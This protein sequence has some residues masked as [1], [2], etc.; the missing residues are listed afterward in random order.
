MPLSPLPKHVF[1]DKLTGFIGRPSFRSSKSDS[2]EKRKSMSE[3]RKSV[4]KKE[5]E[6][7][8]E[9]AKDA[10]AAARFPRSK[11]DGAEDIFVDAAIIR[12]N[13]ARKTKRQKAGSVSVA[14]GAAT[15]SPSKR[16]RRKSEP[17]RN[18]SPLPQVTFK[19]LLSMVRRQSQQEGVDMDPICSDEE[20]DATE[21]SRIDPSAFGT[22][23]TPLPK[24]KSPLRRSIT[25]ETSP[26]IL[27]FREQLHEMEAENLGG[28]AAD[29]IDE[30]LD[31]APGPASE[32]KVDPFA[33]PETNMEDEYMSIA[34]D[35]EEID[36]DAA[37]ADDEQTGADDEEA[38]DK[39]KPE[40]ET[41]DAKDASVSDVDA[42]KDPGQAEMPESA[43]SVS[44]AT[45]ESGNGI[46]LNKDEVGKFLCSCQWIRNP[47]F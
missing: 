36:E 43:D 1:K 11:T 22:P 7:E 38:D 10:A 26:S 18:A 5:K 27:Q 44:K 4:H 31:V 24:S 25:A 40:E 13:T 15:P 23:A 14:V 33:V 12:Q 20:D 8:K 29:D 19:D 2:S 46:V 30:R 42:K 3:K 37:P 39:V 32:K 17:L 6:K 9:R 35:D 28:S 34:G 21:V 41:S 47:N 16:D 45:P